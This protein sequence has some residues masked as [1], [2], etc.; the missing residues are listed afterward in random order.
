MNGTFWTVT[1][2]SALAF[3]LGHLPSFMALYSYTSPAEISPV[4]ILEVILLNGTITFITA[5]FMKKYGFLTAVGIHF[6]ADI[7]WH[8][9]WGLF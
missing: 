2:I 9:I 4:L 5:Y 1:L 8:T 7:V 3:A 6:W